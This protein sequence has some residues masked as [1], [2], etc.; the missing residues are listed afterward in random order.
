MKL[1]FPCSI[2]LVAGMTAFAHAA[3]TDSAGQAKS[4]ITFQALHSQIDALGKETEDDPPTGSSGEKT[5][6]VESNVEQKA[7]AQSTP[8]PA[9]GTKERWMFPE[10]K[11]ESKFVLRTQDG[12]FKLMIHGLL[13]GRFEYGLCR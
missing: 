13:V 10:L 12:D 4:P 8:Q 1:L 2:T 5:E 7:G 6:N 11:D 3:A 9:S